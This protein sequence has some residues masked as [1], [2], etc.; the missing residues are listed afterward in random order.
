MRRKED[1]QMKRLLLLT[2]VLVTVVLAGVLHGNYNHQ[3]VEEGLA[4]REA[5]VV[6][7]PETMPAIEPVTMIDIPF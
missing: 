6:Q 4:L 2:C 7:Y 1:T 3:E 5:Y